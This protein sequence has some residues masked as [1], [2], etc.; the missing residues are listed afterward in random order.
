M[1]LSFFSRNLVNFSAPF[2][3]A[4]DAYEKSAASAL[5]KQISQ[6]LGRRILFFT[7]MRPIN[8][9]QIYP[10]SPKPIHRIRGAREHLTPGSK[11]TSSH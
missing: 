10:Y 1:K 4:I 2:Q 5:L 8:R 7:V 3:I 6:R 9:C 11:R